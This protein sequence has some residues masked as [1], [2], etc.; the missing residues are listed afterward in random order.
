MNTKILITLLAIASI[1]GCTIPG[2]PGITPGTT[3]IGGGGKG[4]EITSFTAEP[5]T[6]YNGSTVK[7]IMEVENQGGSTAPA[8]KSFA[9]LTGTNIKITGSSPGDDAYWHRLSGDNTSDECGDVIDPMKPADIVKGTPGDKEIFKWS[10][11]APNV[12]KGQTSPNS[13]MGRVYTEYMTGVNGNIWVYTEAESDAAKAS[14]RALNK[15]TFVSTSGPVAVQAS[16]APDPV[17]ISGSDKSFTLKITIIN[18]QTGTIYKTGKIPSCPPT[19]SLSTEDLNK[20]D[21]TI[22][23]PDFNIIDTTCQGKQEQELVGGNP[24]DMLCELKVKDTSTPTTFGSFPINIKAE[25][26][27][28]TERTA[29]VTVQGR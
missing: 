16:A 24:T 29:S 25:Y 21:V 4:L 18:S 15:A 2:I 9:Y 3:P 27:Y 10:L 17:V 5:S 7:V 1:A 22:T 13:F 20:V 14:N 28:Y 12:D 11:R 23:A 19:S 6:I 26:G 8:T